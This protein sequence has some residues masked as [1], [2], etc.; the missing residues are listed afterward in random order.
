MVIG[1]E[2]GSG[3]HN[4]PLGT[5]HLHLFLHFHSAITRDA[6]SRKP[7]FGRCWLEPSKGTP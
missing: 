1:S 6:L 3:E 5:P 2:V 4:A 7:G